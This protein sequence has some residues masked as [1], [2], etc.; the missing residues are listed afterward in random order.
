MRASLI[1]AGSVE[2]SAAG[3][4]RTVPRN[5]GQLLP[6]PAGTRSF[7][8]RSP[9]RVYWL[10]RCEG[11]ELKCR[12]GTHGVVEEVVLD[13]SNTEAEALVVR[14]G[15]VLH[16]SVVVPAERVDAV[17]PFEEVLVGPGLA[18]AES[19]APARP[20]VSRATRAASLGA[21]VTTALLAGALALL[22]W[23]AQRTRIVAPRLMR[24]TWS[25]TLSAARRT[26][27][28]WKRAAPHL[29]AGTRATAV[30]IRLAVAAAVLLAS[31]LAQ[32]L[33]FKTRALALRLSSD[34]GLR[35]R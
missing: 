6:P 29:I 21:Q 20:A 11:F 26:R 19:A 12:D 8:R 35:R 1:T 31:A 2:N 15:R 7:G 25:A 27:V 9:V 34:R 28:A 4:G 24:V 16:R 18:P 10:A 14:V 33:A 13:P 22:M 5:G 32:W 3:V 23:M 30:R 17:A